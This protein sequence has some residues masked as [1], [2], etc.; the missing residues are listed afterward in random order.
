MFHI[1]S[2]K[3]NVKNISRSDMQYGLFQTG[4]IDPFASTYLK[5]VQKEER[6]EP[7]LVSKHL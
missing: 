2:T 1:M 3:L 5:I 7:R 4:Q 6:E